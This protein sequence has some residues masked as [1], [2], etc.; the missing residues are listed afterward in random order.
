MNAAVIVTRPWSDLSPQIKAFMLVAVACQLL[1]AVVALVVWW[2]TPADLMPSP[3]RAVWAAVI[4]MV[5][6]GGPILFLALRA[7]AARRAR[8]AVAVPPGG[9]PGRAEML[10]GTVDALYGDG[11]PR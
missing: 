8:E 1:L 3:G 11:E 9:D 5:Q 6:I 10:S 4:V 2:R 7:A